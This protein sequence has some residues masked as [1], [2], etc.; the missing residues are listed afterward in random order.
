MFE[1]IQGNKFSF[2]KDSEIKNSI[3]EAGKRI[4]I[5]VEGYDDKII[6]EIFFYE[7]NNQVAFIDVDGCG[8]VEKYVENCV[9]NLKK[10][11]FY[12]GIIDRDFRT[13]DEIEQ[14][15]ADTKYNNKLFVF[16]ERYTI[17][18]YLIEDNLLLHFLKSKNKKYN[19]YTL[20]KIKILIE[21]TFQDLILLSVGNFILLQ[22]K[23]EF[24]N[25]DASIIPQNFIASR[26][27]EKIYGKN[28]DENNKKEIADKIEDYQRK[29]TL[30]DCENNYHKFISGK[31]FFVY[32]GGKVGFTNFKNELDNLARILVFELKNISKEILHDI[33]DFIGLIKD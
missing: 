7:Y 5:F 8:K 2:I 15:T 11:A 27:A 33:P 9:C 21:E 30:E 13:N 23:K 17:E 14:K 32:F 19:N 28:C 1:K 4:V 31:Y 24:F 18:N 26:V 22:H 16:K 6:F 20:E 10:E 25:K 3:D 29:I 12:F